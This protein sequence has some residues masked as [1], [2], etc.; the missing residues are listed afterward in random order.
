VVLDST[1]S[2]VTEKGYKMEGKEA[3]LAQYETYQKSLLLKIKQPP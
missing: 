1:V 2:Y 3:V